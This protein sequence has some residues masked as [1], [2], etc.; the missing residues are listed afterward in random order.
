[1]KI[2]PID[3]TQKTFTRKIMGYDQD[4]V[5]DFL[6]KI[7]DELE[8]WINERN[9]LRETIREKDLN[10]IEYKE[11]DE[12]LKKTI[13]TATKMAERMHKDSSSEAKLIINNATQKA[14]MIIQEAKASLKDIYNEITYL[15]K[16]RLQF[17]N[18]LRALIH[19]HVS[20][21]DQ[22]KKIMPNPVVNERKINEDPLT[23]NKKKVTTHP[24]NPRSDNGSCPPLG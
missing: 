12:L 11:R 18:N 2:A 16:I 13:S 7:A 14:E 15:K 10:I 1:M 17:E 5:M 4:E 9:T 24:R 8:Q 21:L 20:M 23:S 19:S 6:K 3:I 22:G